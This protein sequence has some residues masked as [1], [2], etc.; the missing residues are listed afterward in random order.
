MSEEE[1]KY[2][3]C[4]KLGDMAV[5]RIGDEVIVSVEFVF[6]PDDLEVVGDEIM[7]QYL[8]KKTFD[9]SVELVREIVATKMNE[10]KSGT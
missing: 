6:Q 7:S 4:R 10:L 5:R 3:G 8:W 9:E 2:T 1:V